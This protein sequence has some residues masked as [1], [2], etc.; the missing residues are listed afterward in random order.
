MKDE[1]RIRELKRLHARALGRYMASRLIGKDATA[2]RNRL[3]S[4][5]KEITEYGKSAG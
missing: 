3:E 4:I 5:G 1:E 2:E